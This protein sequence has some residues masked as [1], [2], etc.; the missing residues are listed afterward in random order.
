[1]PYA[2]LVDTATVRSALEETTRVLR[3]DGADLRVLE[4]DPR[5][6]RIRLQLDLDGVS[7]LECV[8]PPDILEQVLAS[9]L[10]RRIAGEFELLVED[11]RRAT[12]S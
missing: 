7:C 8:L 5:T 12:P 11:P 10:S 2:P 1:M 9:A 4:A 3:A 6:A